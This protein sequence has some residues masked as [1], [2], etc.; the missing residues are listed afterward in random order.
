MWRKETSL[1]IRPYRLAN[2]FNHTPVK[3]RLYIRRRDSRP[4]SLR[5]GS[6]AECKLIGVSSRRRATILYSSHGSIYYFVRYD[7]YTTLRR[8]F[9]LIPCRTQ[10]HKLLQLT[11]SRQTLTYWELRSPN[12]KPNICIL[13]SERTD[14]IL[15]ESSVQSLQWS[16]S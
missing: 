1:D 4:R 7:H 14:I 6:L 10:A 15:R 12:T 16:W 11:Q 2:S 9:V 3:W 8:F 5:A 13:T